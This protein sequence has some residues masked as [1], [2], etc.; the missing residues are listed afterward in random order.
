MSR[1]VV[2]SNRV[3][4]IKRARTGGEGGLAVAVMAAMRERGGLWFGWSGQVFDREPGPPDIFDHGPVTYALVDLMRQDYE[5]YYNGYANRTLWP[6]FHYRLDLTEFARPYFVGYQRVNALFASKLKPLLAADDVIWV[7]DYHL[8]PMAEQLRT[9]G[10]GQRMGFFLHI[11]WP[12]LDVFLA[13]PN[14]REIVR[15]LCAYD[16]V[17]FQTETD[18]RHFFEYI[19]LEADGEVYSDGRVRAFDR[20]LRA[21]AFPISID[22]RDVAEFAEKATGAAPYARLKESLGG[23]DLMI[24]VDR[25]DYSKGLI[26]RMEAVEQLLHSYPGNRD[27]VIT[28]QIA[29]QSRSDVPEYM[30]IRERL[31]SVVGRVN[32]TYAE[33]DWMPIRYLTKG[34]NRRTLAGFLRASRVGLVTPLRDGMN[35]VAKEYVAAQDPK[36]PGVLVLSRFAGAAEELTD[37]IIVNPHD[38]EGMADAMQTALHMPLKERRRRWSAM[39]DWLCEHDIIAWQRSFLDVLTARSARTSA[40]QRRAVAN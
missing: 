23:R 26:Q 2:V 32:G 14:H 20:E 18:L 31:D 21:G 9:A 29:P 5:Q 1:L 13:L 22:T 16:L 40:K 33:F 24:G 39:F 36:D 15:E 17:G 10:C 27:Q 34:F 3:A 11:P 19:E 37:A 25:L 35:L 8:I 4:V 12:P 30:D 38:I 28:L 7:H 6:L